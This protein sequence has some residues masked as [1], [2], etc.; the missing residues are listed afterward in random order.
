MSDKHYDKWGKAA[1]DK[2]VEHLHE[3]QKR[4]KRKINYKLIA[5]QLEED[6]KSWKYTNIQVR[7]HIR[8]LDPAVTKLKGK[9]KEKSRKR[10]RDK[11]S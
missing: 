10:A 7:E 6:D 4:G 8:H 9:S 2:A 3:Q 5:S 1:S 11:G